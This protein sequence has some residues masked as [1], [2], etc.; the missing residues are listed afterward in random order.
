MKKQ[1]LI[2]VVLCI[3]C[4]PAEAQRIASAQ[5][6]APADKPNNP[7]ITQKE[8]TTANPNPVKD[9]VT[10]NGA[11]VDKDSP[12]NAVAKSE[13]DSCTVAP[14]TNDKDPRAVTVTL[15]DNAY[16]IRQRVCLAPSRYF[17]LEFPP[18]DEVSIVSPQ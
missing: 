6:K 17:V 3:V 13:K 15:A 7:S 4:L 10:I 16:V 1:L 8:P 11:T 5:R 18:D 14:A 12:T 2:L 9:P